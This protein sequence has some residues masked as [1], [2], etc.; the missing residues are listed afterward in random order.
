MK[1]ERE[2]KRSDHYHCKSDAEQENRSIRRV[3]VLASNV[4]IDKLIG[5]GRMGDMSKNGIERKRSSPG[6][7]KRLKLRRADICDTF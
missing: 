5:D 7:A 6:K 3:E 2:S 1:Y 4:T